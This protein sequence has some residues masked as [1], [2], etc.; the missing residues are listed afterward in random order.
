MALNFKDIPTQGGGWFKPDTDKVEFAGFLVE[1]HEWERQRPTQHGPKDSALCDITMFA[2][3]E[4]LEAGEP[5]EVLKGTRVENS[6]LAR[7]LESVKGGATIVTLAQI[8]PSKPGRH[9]AWVWR[10][11]SNMVKGKVMAYGEKREAAVTEAMADAP[12]FD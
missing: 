1:V 8:P 7:D 3:M 9:P 6:I 11:A 12:S 2:T 10:Q 5:T 4:E